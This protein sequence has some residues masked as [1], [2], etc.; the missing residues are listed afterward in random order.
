MQ[1]YQELVDP[2]LTLLKSKGT[3]E[4]RV[5]VLI[6]FWVFFSFSVTCWPKHKTWNSWIAQMQVYQNLVDPLL[7]LLMSKGTFQTGMC[8][9][10]H[11]WVFFSFSVTSMDPNTKSETCHLSIATVPNT[12]GHFYQ[13]YRCLKGY[14]RQECVHWFTS[15]RFPVLVTSV[16]PNINL[17]LFISQM[18]LY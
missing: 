9:L 16:D 6:H 18:Q 1:V 17:K 8:A 7:M 12:C 15:G 3:F 4:T 11:F 14:C 2:L 13:H 5:Y 10:V